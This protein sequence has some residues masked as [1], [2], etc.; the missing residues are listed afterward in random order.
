MQILSG[1]TSEAT[2]YMIDDYPYGRTVRCRKRVWLE[3]KEKKGYRIVSQTEHPTKKIWN[4]PA[5][6]NYSEIVA[7]LYLDDSGHVQWASVHV[8][9]TAEKALEFAKQFGR[10]CEGYGVF[11]RWAAKKAELIR[12]LISGARYFTVNGE[13]SERSQA[14]NDRDNAEALIWESIAQ[15]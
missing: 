15:F 1:H 14:D 8:Y 9:T 12:Q 2:A 4:K 5:K 6:S 3:Y 11:K 10:T 13:R 7:C